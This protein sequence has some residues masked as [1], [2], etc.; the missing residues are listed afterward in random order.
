M[1]TAGKVVAGGVGLAAVGGIVWFLMRKKAVRTQEGVDPVAT[2]IKIT[3]D[4]QRQI[5]WEGHS[6]A[7][8]ASKKATKGKRVPRSGSEAQL[9]T[10]YSGLTSRLSDVLGAAKAE[11]RSKYGTSFPTANKV[12]GPGWGTLS[13]WYLKKMNGMDDPPPADA[14]ATVKAMDTALKAGTIGIDCSIQPGVPCGYPD[15]PASGCTGHYE[16][17]NKRCRTR[18]ASK[19]TF[20]R[21]W[22]APAGVS[23]FGSY[24]YVPEEA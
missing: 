12:V 22:Q 1:N 13:T 11:C 7:L 23:G 24:L 14:W 3:D 4:G 9:A 2:S 18:G 5:D 21:G 6:R 15:A 19:K 8:Q 16:C 17:I 10:W 20:P